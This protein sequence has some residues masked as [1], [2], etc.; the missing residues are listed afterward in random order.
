MF[1]Q[2]SLSSALL[3]LQPSSKT[4]SIHRYTLATWTAHY[5]WIL[6]RTLGLFLK[7]I[8]VQKFISKHFSFWESAFKI[9]RTTREA[10]WVLLENVE[11]FYRRLQ[12]ANKSTGLLYWKNTYFGLRFV[13]TNIFFAR[14]S[15]YLPLIFIW[16]LLWSTQM[17]FY[18]DVVYLNQSTSKTPNY[19]TFKDRV[20]RSSNFKQWQL[21]AVDLNCRKRWAAFLHVYQTHV[22]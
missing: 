20:H 22:C 10:F 17:L 21:F 6:N 9:P 12:S 16:K 19:Y 18:S 14:F 1:R 15:H 13:Q 4:I 8:C 2:I 3:K 7:P 11:S 5:L